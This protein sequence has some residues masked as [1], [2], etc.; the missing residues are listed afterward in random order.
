MRRFAMALAA[1][2][3]VG[4]SVQAQI[5]PVDP[6]QNMKAEQTKDQEGRDLKFNPTQLGG[7]L[8]NP[9]VTPVNVRPSMKF[10]SLIKLRADFE[11]EMTKS[12]EQL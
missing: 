9:G 12:V 2:M 6:C 11:P 10:K 5:I 7:C 8:A 3:V 1:L 4:V